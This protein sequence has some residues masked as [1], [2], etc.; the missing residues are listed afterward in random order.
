MY[1]T[2]QVYKLILSQDFTW[3]SIFDSA[4]N[5][6][7][8][9]AKTS[10]NDLKAAD[11]VERVKEFVDE[12]PQG[13]YELQFKKRPTGG[14]DEIHRYKISTLQGSVKREVD[15]EAIKNDLKEKIREELREEARLLKR[16]TEITDLKKEY[17]S[18]LKELNTAGGKVNV[19]LENF[20]LK[21]M[22]TSNATG[23]LAGESRPPESNAETGNK[24]FTDAEILRVNNALKIMLEHMD[25]DTFCL[26]AEKVKSSPGVVTTLKNFL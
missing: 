8:Y 16:E 18:K 24:K 3:C 5:K 9:F 19:L 12:F 17:E 25:I 15:M 2:E 6:V 11:I 1:T 23:N 14:A 4:K 21:I 22:G 13:S 7:G 26:F 20:L 10:T